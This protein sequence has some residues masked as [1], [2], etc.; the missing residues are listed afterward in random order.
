MG[1]WVA[2]QIVQEFEIGRRVEALTQ[3]ILI[4]YESYKMN[5][6]NGAMAGW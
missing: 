3:G 6:F 2:G 1:Y 5:N 4:A